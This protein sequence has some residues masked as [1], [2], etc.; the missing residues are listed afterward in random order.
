MPILLFPA[1]FVS[2]FAFGEAAAEYR[3]ALLIENA[4]SDDRSASSIEAELKSIATELRAF[5]FRC[6]LATN[7]DEK[8][9][10]STIESF[11]ARTPTRSTALLYFS[12]KVSKGKFNDKPVTFLQG[13]NSRPGRGFALAEAF[14]YLETK[15]GS[16]RNL[17]VANVP[18][19]PVKLR[20]E[21]PEDSLLAFFSES[22]TKELSGSDDL[23]T[24]L[25]SNSAIHLS[26][27]EG[28]ATVSG[29]GSQA[30]TP[31]DQFATGKKA[32]D[33][34]VNA[35]GM[36]FCWCPP[37]SFTAGSPEGIPG[38]FPDE[39]Q[40]PVTIS[41]GFWISKYELTLSQSLRNVSRKTIARHKLDP[42][43]MMNHD[44]AKSSTTRTF[45]QAER[46]AGRLPEDWQY[47][48]PTEDQWEYAA[49][50]GTKS[51]F[52]FGEDLKLLPRHANFG[53]K[54]YFDSKDIFSNSAD[55]SLSDGVVRLAR[56]GSFEPN[57][58]GLY[59]MYGNVSEWCI[60]LA[61]RGGSWVSVPENCRSA[62]RDSFSSRNEQ[63]FIGYR[64]VIQKTPPEAKKPSKK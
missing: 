1:V 43:T 39:E 46:K 32:G 55:R 33:E 16:S 47:S 52:Y 30:I 42:L 59:D 50:A 24:T 21:L 26:R 14:R 53:D 38:R 12:G 44:D 17:V 35:R 45:S 23:L 6:E 13:T 34:W 61:V 15:G 19:P 41:D 27:L 28:D 54:S 64:L 62:Y 7:L 5:G 10:K 48:L 8:K 20:T 29:K 3:V 57:P 25:N 60:N 2:L 11:T 63:N 36:I 9:I 40:R 49:R 51:R 58:W 56:V 22:F 18:E 4:K 37:G 31:P